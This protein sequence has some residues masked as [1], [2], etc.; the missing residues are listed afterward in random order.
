VLGLNLF[1]PFTANKLF[2]ERRESQAVEV[3]TTNPST[4]EAEAG[5][6]QL[7]TSWFT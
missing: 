7:K 2:S 3:H 4:G 5:R 1:I 6:S